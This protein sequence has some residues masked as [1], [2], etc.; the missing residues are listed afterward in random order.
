[1]PILFGDS[2]IDHELRDERDEKL[3]TYLKKLK[4]WPDDYFE[5]VFPERLKARRAA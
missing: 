3:A 1:L 5:K 4:E 2:L